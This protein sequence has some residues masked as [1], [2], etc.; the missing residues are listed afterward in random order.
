MKATARKVI[1]IAPEQARTV[2]IRL[3]PSIPEEA[4]FFFLGQALRRI[5][6][7]AEKYD[8]DGDGKV[9]SVEIQRDFAK[10]MNHEYFLAIAV[11]EGR[12]TAHFLA[13]A[14]EYERKLYVWVKQ[15]EIDEGE[16]APPGQIK[17]MF[18]LFDRWK[19]DI[20]AAG[21]RCQAQTEAHV[22]LYKKM[23]W[24]HKFTVMMEGGTS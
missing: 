3:E 14:V 15:W 24:K 12:I 21:M 5:R 22:R 2:V 20:G 11:R 4:R 7:F 6:E 16:K 19:R 1:P 8:T 17:Q 18:E 13:Q 23:G 10:E 9:L